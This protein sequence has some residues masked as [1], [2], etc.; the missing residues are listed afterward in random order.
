MVR[1]G[2]VRRS[3]MS[4]ED[5]GLKVIDDRG[6]FVK[7]MCHGDPARSLWF[8]GKPLPLCSRCTMLYPFTLIFTLFGIW[9]FSFI[10]MRVLYVF[11]IFLFLNGPLVI[12][13]Y[14]QYIGIRE[15][16]NTLRSITGALAGS[17][18]GLSL[19]FLMSS[20]FI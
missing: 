11:I 18:I 9:F 8:N 5:I 19:G 20:I 10:S 14:T 12:D 16:N 3:E 13:G 6:R 17:G 7:K 1:K 15:S 2:P 4:R